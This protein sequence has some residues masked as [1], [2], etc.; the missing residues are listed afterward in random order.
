MREQLGLDIQTA[1]ANSAYITSMIY[2]AMED[3]GIQMHTPPNATGGVT[4]KVELKQEDFSYNAENDCFICPM[5]HELHLK[6]L[7]REQHNICRT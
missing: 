1:S 4:Y 3:M 5:G 2:R 7:E 6:S